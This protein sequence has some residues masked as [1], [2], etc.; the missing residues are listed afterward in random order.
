VA[1]ELVWVNP[2]SVEELMLIRIFDPERKFL[3]KL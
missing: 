3:G 2:P 1:R